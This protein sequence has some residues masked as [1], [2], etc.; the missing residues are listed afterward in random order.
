MSDYHNSPND[1]ARV[2]VQYIASPTRVRSEVLS[3]FGGA[4]TLTDISR[5]RSTYERSVSRRHIRDFDRTV[6]WM[7]E[8]HQRNMDLAN[9]L[10]VA[11]LYRELEAA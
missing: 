8:R 2:L 6:V 7:D 9:R 5:M 3:S 10:F 11:A 4:P 1:M